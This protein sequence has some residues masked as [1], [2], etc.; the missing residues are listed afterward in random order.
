MK[1][2][3]LFKLAMEQGASDIH[4]LAGNLPI[5]R[6]D[7]VLQRLTNMPEMT[8]QLIEE[9]VIP[10]LTGEQKSKFER[11]WELDFSYE[12]PGYCRLRVNLHREKGSIG[13]VARIIPS[14]IPTMEDVNMPGVVY[15]II[16][17]DRGL[18][19][20]TGPAGCG[21]S[22]SLAAM[23]NLINKEQNRHIITLED[24]IEF[25][26]T[27]QKSIVRQR[28]LDIDMLSFQESLGHVLRQDPNVLMVGEMRDLETIASTITLAETGHLVLATLHTYDAGQTIDRIVDIF[29]PHQQSQIRLQVSITLKGII[30]QRLLPQVDGGR[31]AARE[32]LLN[33]PAISYLI[34]DN[35]INQIR[36][37]MQTSAKEGMFT[38]DQDLRGLY[39]RGLI[40]KATAE[41]HMVDPSALM[42]DE[43]EKEER[44]KK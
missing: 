26:F 23:I 1:L 10:L 34:R 41:S 3:Q 13:L 24:P 17:Q 27:S 16:R 32:I 40:T 38:M 44:K 6:V 18:I 43:E 22:T 28:Q 2:E 9:L 37:V 29:P 35:K 19:L 31:I 39:K 4:L 5:F 21:K 11:L 15:D 20:L 12:L 8:G 7:G 36:S 33:N 14:V 42:E 25:V 30:S